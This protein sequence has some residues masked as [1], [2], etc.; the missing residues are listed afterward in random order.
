MMKF[1]LLWAIGILIPTIGLH[2][3]EVID[4]MVIYEAPSRQGRAASGGSCTPQRT[5]WKCYIHGSNGRSRQ[6]RFGFN[7]DSHAIV[8]GEE[9]T[10]YAFPSMAA[11]MVNDRFKCGGTLIDESHILTA[12]H[13]VYGIANLHHL[14]VYLSAHDLRKVKDYLTDAKADEYRVRT[15]I[16]HNK[17]NHRTLENDIAILTLETTAHVWVGAS[18]ICLDSSSSTYVNQKALVTGWGRLTAGG[19]HSSVLRAVDVT[20]MS[21]AQCVEK[22]RNTGPEVVKDTNICASD[23]GKDACKGDSG[24]PL[25]TVK[26][27]YNGLVQVGIVSWGMPCNAQINSP[28]VYT[29]VSKYIKWIRRIQE[30]Y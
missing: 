18:P 11:I 5:Y 9:T 20:V 4:D 16:Y 1:I 28:G 21:N 14:R 12:A 10:R 23:P 27:G 29:R 2:A 24:G 19:S 26:S 8:G 13:C 6:K 7:I 25:F 30:C 15:I 22:Y 3:Q 17:Y